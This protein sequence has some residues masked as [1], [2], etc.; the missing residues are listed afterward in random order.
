MISKINF[1]GDRNTENKKDNNM[2]INE[3]K[4]DQS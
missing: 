2:N 3:H 4:K 1:F